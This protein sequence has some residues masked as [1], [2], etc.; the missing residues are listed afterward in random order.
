MQ[1]GVLHG[2]VV[3]LTYHGGGSV[4]VMSAG[5]IGLLDCA[6]LAVVC[7]VGLK[8]R[9]RSKRKRK[10]RCVEDRCE[11]NPGPRFIFLSTSNLGLEE[12]RRLHKRHTK[13]WT[14]VAGGEG[15]GVAVTS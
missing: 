3:S 10:E 7:R 4:G 15:R 5:L 12:R 6:G 2:A 8:Q 1:S 13:K 14:R 9:K 11:R